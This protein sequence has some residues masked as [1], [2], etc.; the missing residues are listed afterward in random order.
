M[1]GLELANSYDQIFREYLRDSLRRGET[2]A[3]VEALMNCL[4]HSSL[5]NGECHAI[6]PPPSLT[7]CDTQISI[8][9]TTTELDATTTTVDV[10]ATTTIDVQDTNAVSLTAT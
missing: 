9:S 10:E 4:I 7:S 1:M 3:F 8:E 5:L 2:R 6:G